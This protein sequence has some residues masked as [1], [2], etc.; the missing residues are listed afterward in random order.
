MFKTDVSLGYCK[1][2][3]K[4]FLQHFKLFSSSSCQGQNQSTKYFA[5]QHVKMTESSQFLRKPKMRHKINSKIYPE[6]RFVLD[7]MYMTIYMQYLILMSWYCMILFKS[8]ICIIYLH[9]YR[10]CMFAFDAPTLDCGNCCR[11]QAMA[12]ALL[13]VAGLGRCQAMVYA[14]CS[15]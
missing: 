10:F 5:P 1:T 12:P 9:G 14:G 3:L 2:M 13:D 4:K 8:I 6:V 15:L 7:C 11:K